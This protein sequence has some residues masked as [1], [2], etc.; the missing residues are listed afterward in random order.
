MASS[1]EMW[2]LAVYTTLQRI[3]VMPF[4]KRGMMKAALSHLSEE[5]SR[6]ARRKYRKVWRR[7]LARAIKAFDSL[8]VREQER[9]CIDWSFTCY[10][11][12]EGAMDMLKSMSVGSKP[13]KKAR[14]ARL[15]LV[16][17]SERF[18]TE[19]KKV[20]VELGVFRR[21]VDF[22]VGKKRH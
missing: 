6:K 7:E 2:E 20:A 8:S 12:I 4:H 15:H 3:G 14:H 18:S 16:R 19:F 11:G 17:F 13:N 22:A 10:D 9:T 1:K 5:E 21:R